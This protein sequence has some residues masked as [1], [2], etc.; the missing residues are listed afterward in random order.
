VRKFDVLRVQED[1]NGQS[2]IMRMF[3]SA[4]RGNVGQVSGY[5]WL[6]PVSRFNLNLDDYIQSSQAWNCGFE[7]ASIYRNGYVHCDL[8]PTNG[9][10][11]L[12]STSHLD[13]TDNRQLIKRAP[14]HS[15]LLQPS[16]P[17]FRVEH[18][19]VVP[20]HLDLFRQKASINGY[21]PHFYCNAFATKPTTATHFAVSLHLTE[22]H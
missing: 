4:I 13:L 6:Q 11:A 20:F 8:K 16:T 17:D 9:I 2:A 22:F 7:L 5:K 10:L 21:L 3:F 18:S 12:L 14:G 1:L 15:A 19:T